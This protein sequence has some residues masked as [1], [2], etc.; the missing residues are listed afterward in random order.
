MRQLFI[1][2][3]FLPLIRSF[4]QKVYEYPVTLKQE[5][6]DTIWGKV[7]YDPYRWLED[8]NS[9]ETQEWIK[10]QDKAK[11]KCYGATYYP[12]I[13]YLSIYSNIDYKPIFREGKYYFMYVYEKREQ[14]PSLYYQKDED[15]E[16]K[17]L[18]N[19]NIP[20]ENSTVT[21]DE[22]SISSDNKTLA[23]ELSKNSSDWKTIRFLDIEH[24]KLLP[25]TV[26]LLNIAQFIGRQMASF[27]LNTMLAPH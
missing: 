9:N 1:I 24:K 12:L 22:I 26:T 13:K 3:L 17:F 20:G 7:V 10:Q 6:S 8:I 2:I 23:L 21:I 18:F 25:D 15:K 11:D 19:P 16:P 4:G 14:T 5:T 27:T